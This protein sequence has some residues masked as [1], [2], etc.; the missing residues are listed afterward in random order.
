MTGI[1]LF[2][3][4]NNALSSVAGAPKSTAGIMQHAPMST[5]IALTSAALTSLYI[6]CI[7]I[8][9]ILLGY[10]LIGG[11]VT[12]QY[13][14]GAFMM[15]ILSWLSGTAL[16][17]V[18]YAL[19]PWLPGTTQLIQTF[20]MRANMFSSGKM[21]LAN[22]LPGFMLSLFAWNPL[23]HCI[24][25]ARSYTFKNYDSDVTSAT[26]PL[27]ISIIFITLGLL[28]EFFT[29]KNASASWDAKR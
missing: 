23:F 22:Q 28:S 26:Y 24:D 2:L 13:L 27:I 14:P 4:H 6:Q 3:T 25:Q 16:G 12:F 5:V 29:R 17:I 9:T 8:F 10:S 18:L 19:S 7:S 15:F 21:F 11:D 20:Y 1:F